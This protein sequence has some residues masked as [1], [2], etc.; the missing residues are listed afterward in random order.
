MIS[1]LD[2]GDRVTALESGFTGLEDSLDQHKND[3]NSRIVSCNIK[4]F[5]MKYT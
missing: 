1:D 2:H 4:M 5:M 3:F